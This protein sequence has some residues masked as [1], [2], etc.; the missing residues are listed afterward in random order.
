MMKKAILCKQNNVQRTYC[1][2]M[3]SSVRPDFV[4]YTS[5]LG[6]SMAS[7]YGH[8]EPCYRRLLI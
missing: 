4:E 8:I 6:K 3:F 2:D 7:L 5:F 1:A